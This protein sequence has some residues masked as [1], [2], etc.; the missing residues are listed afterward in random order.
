MEEM[1]VELEKHMP[2][3]L[4]IAH[5]RRKAGEGEQ[6]RAHSREGQ[7]L[8]NHRGT[9]CLQAAG[10]YDTCAFAKCVGVIGAVP[11][12]IRAAAAAAA[13][14]TMV[15]TALCA[16]AAKAA[17]IMVAALVLAPIRAKLV[18]AVAFT[19]LPPITPDHIF[20]HY[21]RPNARF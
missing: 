14:A 16:A 7:H 20:C 1:A 13:A 3:I 9:N 6:N 10:C 11:A 8:R 18:A 19:P 17:A 2:R 5:Q 21:S 15:Q 4:L 12:A